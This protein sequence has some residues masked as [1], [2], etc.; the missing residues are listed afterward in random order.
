MGGSESKLAGYASW[1]LEERHRQGRD[2]EPLA[3]TVRIA[4]EAVGRARALLE[5]AGLKL[6]EQVG[7]ICMGHVSPRNIQRLTELEEVS[8]LEISPPAEMH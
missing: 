8:H 4:P 2:D 6:D 7:D 3:V 1:I 5:S